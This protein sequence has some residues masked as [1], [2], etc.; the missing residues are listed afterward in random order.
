M[1]KMGSSLTKTET[2]SSDLVQVKEAARNCPNVNQSGKGYGSRLGN[3]NDVHGRDAVV[4]EDSSFSLSR[5]LLLL[6]FMW[7]LMLLL[8]VVK[9]ILDHVWRRWLISKFSLNVPLLLNPLSFCS[10]CLNFQA[11]D[12]LEY[13]SFSIAA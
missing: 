11:W 6:L 5:R 13:S 4:V 1:D 3:T 9:G 2:V 8:L 7:W 10:C 12:F